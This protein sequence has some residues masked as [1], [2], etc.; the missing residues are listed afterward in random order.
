ME[1]KKTV[2]SLGLSLGWCDW[3][4]ILTG[5]LSEKL[6]AVKTRR[7]RSCEEDKSYPGVSWEM[8]EPVLLKLDAYQELKVSI[9]LPY[10]FDFHHYFFIWLQSLLF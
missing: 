2:M 5:S 8:W 9:S 3:S 10:W 7:S 6:E 4:N 1:K